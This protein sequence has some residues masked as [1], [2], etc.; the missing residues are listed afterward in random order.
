MFWGKEDLCSEVREEVGKRGLL[1]KLGWKSCEA[2][3]QGQVFSHIVCPSWL[4]GVLAGPELPAL[5][6]SARC[7]LGSESESRKGVNGH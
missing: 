7:C 3:V 6:T 4:A 2:V 5:G 1:D